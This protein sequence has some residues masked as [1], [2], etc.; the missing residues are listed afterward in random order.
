MTLHSKELIE[1]AKPYI[2][3]KKDPK[4]KIADPTFKPPKELNAVTTGM[5]LLDADLLDGANIDDDVKALVIRSEGDHFGYGVDLAA[6]FKGYK[7]G[8][9]NSPL[10]EFRLDDDPSIEFHW[11]TRS[12][13]SRAATSTP[14]PSAVAEASILQES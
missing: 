6:Q 14:S 3:Y 1:E 5:R 8:P 13:I 12:A 9:K 10:H 11:M 2:E 7:E 4:T